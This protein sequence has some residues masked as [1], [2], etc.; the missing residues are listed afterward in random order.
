MSRPGIKFIYANFNTN[1]S[2]RLLIRK[3]ILLQF[4]V[5]DATEAAVGKY[6]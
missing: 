1:T 5:A 3:L 6:G 4:G 2:R